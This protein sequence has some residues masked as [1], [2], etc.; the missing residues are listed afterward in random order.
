MQTFLRNRL[1]PKLQPEEEKQLKASE[2]KWPDF[3]QTI[4]RLAERHHLTV[5]WQTLPGARS[6]WEA[7]RV[8]SKAGGKG[9]GP[10]R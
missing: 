6:D 3:P 10:K 8:R 5:P 4:E 2:G 9:R 7:L 1:R